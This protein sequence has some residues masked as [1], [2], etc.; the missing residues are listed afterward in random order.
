MQGLRVMLC[1][2]T[3][4]MLSTPKEFCRKAHSELLNT[5]IW[6]VYLDYKIP[7]LL[8]FQRAVRS[9]EEIKVWFWDST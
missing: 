2:P 6:M 9:T 5:K 7:E 4:M 3:H 1:N 8:T